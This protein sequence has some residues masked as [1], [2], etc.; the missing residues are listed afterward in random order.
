MTDR[1]DASD[2]FDW[3]G[4]LIRRIGLH[5]RSDGAVMRMPTPSCWA[6]SPLLYVSGPPAHCHRPDLPRRPRE[7]SSRRI[8][9]R[10]GFPLNHAHPADSAGCRGGVSL[11]EV[12]CSWIND[13][14]FISGI[15]MQGDFGYR[16]SFPGEEKDVP[17]PQHHSTGDPI[18]IIISQS[19]A[20]ADAR[21]CK[22]G[23]RF[24]QSTF[25][26]ESA[27]RSSTPETTDQTAL[28][29]EIEPL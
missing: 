18:P 3:S 5:D 6:E 20:V 13:I 12:S 9:V 17:P 1:S 23:F 21:R 27:S 8:R 29:D 16:T 25:P 4:L 7:P 22:S 24:R 15:Y 10:L 19:D 26:F 14:P 28:E 11:T 2:L